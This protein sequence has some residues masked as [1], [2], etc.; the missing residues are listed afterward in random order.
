MYCYFNL[1]ATFFFFHV[2]VISI[3]MP[4]GKTIKRFLPPVSDRFYLGTCH[5]GGADVIVNIS[6]WIEVH[7]LLCW[8]MSTELRGRH[9][10]MYLKRF[11]VLHLTLR[12][13]EVRKSHMHKYEIYCLD[14]T[15]SWSPMDEPAFILSKLNL[16][17]PHV[18]YHSHSTHKFI[19]LKGL[20]FELKYFSFL[21]LINLN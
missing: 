18:N 17:P 8:W 13:M 14:L 6:S 11:T 16:T 12:E 2:L 1:N 7:I 4:Q 10:C 15:Q 5:S 3:P 21:V 19:I 20:N 9:C